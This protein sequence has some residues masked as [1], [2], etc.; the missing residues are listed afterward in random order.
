[1]KVLYDHQIFQMQNFGGISRYFYELL[2]ES[3]RLN[4]YQAKLPRIISANEYLVS[5]QAFNVHSFGKKFHQKAYR[6]INLVNKASSRM[7]FAFDNFDIFHPT[8]FETY[9]LGHTKKPFVITIYDLINEIYP[10]YFLNNSALLEKRKM[11]MQKAQRI[12]AISQNTKNDIMKFYDIPESKIDVTYLAESLS[13]VTS[14]KVD[15]L[16][17]RYLLFVGNRGGYKN[18]ENFYQAVVPLLKQNADLVVVCAG[19]N[20]FN[21][22]EQQRM[23]T[24]KLKMQF[25]Y[26][27]FKTNE[28]LKYLYEKALCFVFPSLYEGFG[29]PVLEAFAAGCLVCVSKNSSLKEIV[30]EAGLYFNPNSPEDIRASLSMALSLQKD[31]IYTKKAAL[32][33]AKYSWEITCTETYKVY[34]KC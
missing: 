5:D 16:P 20:S 19:G 11:L 1:M 14:K 26:I 17:S 28:D 34:Q 29:I 7:T 8:F 21:T 12:I 6:G 15:G 4:L 33:L 25:Q 22:E 18:F 32:E 24:D 9:F 13:K 31:N 27:A 23:E 10:Q 2:S 3:Q 30:G